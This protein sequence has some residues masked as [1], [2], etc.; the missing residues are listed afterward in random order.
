MTADATAYPV[1]EGGTAQVRVIVTGTVDS[2]VPVT[3]RTAACADHRPA[4]RHVAD[5]K[6]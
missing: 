4:P 6:G 2:P 3:H 5:A 1:A